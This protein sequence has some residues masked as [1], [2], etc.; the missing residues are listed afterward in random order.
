ML[1]RLFVFMSAA[2]GQSSSIDERNHNS[3]CRTLSQDLE[4]EF[5][6]VNGVYKGEAE[7]S[8]M[9][10]VQDFNQ[11]GLLIKEAVTYSQESIL[12]MDARKKC[13]LF[14]PASNTMEYIGTMWVSDTKPLGVDAYTEANGQ[15]LYTL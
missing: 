9:V 1:N 7:R 10:Q 2:R 13:F 12:I 14:Y 6:E 3:L 8:V 5:D 15:F 11:I 4:Y